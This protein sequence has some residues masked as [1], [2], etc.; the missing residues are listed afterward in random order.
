MV[1]ERVFLVVLF[2]LT[3]QSFRNGDDPVD[4]VLTCL[5]IVSFQVFVSVVCPALVILESALVLFF[6][7]IVSHVNTRQN[8]LRIVLHTLAKVKRLISI[9]S[10]NL[11]LK[12]AL[13]QGAMLNNLM[14][15]LL[16]LSFV[17]QTR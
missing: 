16:K 3:L 14:D 2:G 10:M 4:V 7:V 6:G 8:E 12:M 1:L 9:N 17:H 13:L 11:R 5:E 15:H